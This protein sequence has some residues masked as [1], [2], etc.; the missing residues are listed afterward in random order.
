MQFHSQQKS[1]AHHA[2][3]YQRLAQLIA[4]TGPPNE[5]SMA[6]GLKEGSYWEKIATE[7]VKGPPERSMIKAIYNL[8]RSDYFVK[9]VTE[10]LQLKVRYENIYKDHEVF[11]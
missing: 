5:T 2:L 3:D 7:Y 10:M 9:L 11:S 6:A 1:R 8:W 4:E